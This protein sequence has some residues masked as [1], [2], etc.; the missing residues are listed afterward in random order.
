MNED[1]HAKKEA[2]WRKLHFS[3]QLRALWHSGYLYKAAGQLR[4][5]IPSPFFQ[6]VRISQR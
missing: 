6:L 5:G 4:G 1:V 3:R 2:L